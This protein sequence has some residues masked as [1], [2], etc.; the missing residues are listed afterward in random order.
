MPAI[1]LSALE[2]AKLFERFAT[3]DSLIWALVRGP[4]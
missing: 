2:G 3:D 4:L 1:N